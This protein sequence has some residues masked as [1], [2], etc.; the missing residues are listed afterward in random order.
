MG[1]HAGKVAVI[2]AGSWGS[3]V[4]GLVA[5]HAREV[6]LWAHSPVSVDYFNQTH[7][8][9]RYLVN[10]QLP[11]Q[12]R[13]T[14]SYDEA[15][16]GADAA[17]L[18]VPSVHLRATCA[19]VADALDASVPVAVLSKGIEQKTGKLMDQ[20]AAEELGGAER[21]CVLS[22]PNHAE[23][24]CLGKPAGAVVAG[25]S[26]ATC[27]A[28]RDLVISEHFRVYLSDD[29]VGVEVCGAVKNV[30]AIACGIAAGSGFGD[31]ALAMIMT[32][33]LAEISRLACALG[34]Q[35]L[36]CMGLAGM[37]DLVVTCT[38]PHSRNR[39]FGKSFARGV[40]LEDY[41]ASRH[42]V[43]EGAVAARSVLEV[44]ERLG[45]EAPITRAVHALLYEGAS[46]S[47]GFSQLVSRE[48]HEEFY[49]L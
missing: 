48:P 44:A 28:I 6:L 47:E 15:I 36:T 38:S 29:P 17:F 40:S 4:A 18:V 31:N 24:V 11:C 37:G 21:I 30:I 45:V 12:V 3:A 25:R 32:R 5:A 14:S 43:V 9:P 49:G 1:M 41:Q 13:M 42:M 33:G 46:V 19:A 27:S 20:V 7:H 10:Y 23:E 35:P 34:A 2:G 8:N 16:R 22:G 26:V 39:D